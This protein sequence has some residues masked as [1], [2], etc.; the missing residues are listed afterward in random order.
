MD[1]L[2]TNGADVTVTESPGVVVGPDAARA[3]AAVTGVRG[4][5]PVQH[6][7]GYV[8]ADLQDVYG[9]DPAT[10]TGVAVLQDAYFQ[11][12]T[13]RGLMD[14]LSARCPPKLVPIR[15]SFG[16]RATFR[17]QGRFLL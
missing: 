7:F 4:V 3:L 5:E 11:G 9:V 10:I 1:A 16:T 2:L 8:G 12:G 13:A 14:T 6:R 15:S 17:E